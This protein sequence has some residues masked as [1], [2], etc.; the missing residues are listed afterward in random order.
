MYRLTV[1][2]NFKVKE[3]AGGSEKSQFEITSLEI[4]F[5]ISN[6]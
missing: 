2:E 4:I 6:I 1:F 3:R 5:L